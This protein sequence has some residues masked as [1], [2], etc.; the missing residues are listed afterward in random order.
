V[1]VRLLSRTSRN[2]LTLVPLLKTWPGAS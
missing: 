1:R 2:L